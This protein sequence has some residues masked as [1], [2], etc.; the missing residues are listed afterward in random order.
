MPYHLL[1]I[2]ATEWI[3]HWLGD[4]PAQNSAIALNKRF[5]LHQSTVVNLKHGA[6]AFL[7]GSIYTTPFI[8]FYLWNPLNPLTGLDV[9]LGV[10]IGLIHVII[11]YFNLGAMWTRV[12]NWDWSDWRVTTPKAPFFVCLAID[13]G[14]HH[15]TNL[16]LLSL[17]YR[18]EWALLL[19]VFS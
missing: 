17:P 4:Y 11:D 7:H 19:K 16:A 1:L 18:Q 12:Y 13:Q 6:I 8:A 9:R 5:A 10:A 3:V 14:L 15:C 2:F